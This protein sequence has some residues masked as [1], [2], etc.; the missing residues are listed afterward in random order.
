[1]RIQLIP[2]VEVNAS[3]RALYDAFT[4]RIRENYATF[5]AIALLGPWSAWLRVPETGEAICRR[6]RSLLRV[7]TGRHRFV[8]DREQSRDDAHTLERNAVSGARGFDK[9][10]PSRVR[11]AAGALCRRCARGRS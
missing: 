7:V 2:E 6:S 9:R 8:F 5:K 10:T 1:M 3:Q 11:P 4:K